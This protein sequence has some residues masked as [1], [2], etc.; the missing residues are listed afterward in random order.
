MYAVVVVVIVSKALLWSMITI[1]FVCQVLVESDVWSKQVVV[2][3][4]AYI[5]SHSIGHML[6]PQKQNVA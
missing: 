4:I 5:G 1:I 2:N 3:T 6:Y